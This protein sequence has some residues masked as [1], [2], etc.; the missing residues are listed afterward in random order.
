MERQK[1]RGLEDWEQQWK[2]RGMEA[3][4]QR[5]GNGEQKLVIRN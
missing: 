5:D 1:I 2:R 3:W 4:E